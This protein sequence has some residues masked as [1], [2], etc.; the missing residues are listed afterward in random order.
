[1]PSIANLPQAE[2]DEIRARLKRIEGQ[3]RGVQKMIDEGRDCVEVLN[4]LAAIKAAVNGLT[5]ELLE[6][7]ALRCLQ[8]PED[9]PSQEAAVANMVR[10]LVRSG[11]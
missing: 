5:G 8:H 1:M 9:F 11:R 10:T 3:A 6:A 4:Q 2:Q 7:Y